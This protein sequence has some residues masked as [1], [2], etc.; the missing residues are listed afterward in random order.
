MID[1]MAVDELPVRISPC[2]SK[3]GYLLFKKMKIALAKILN[4]RIQKVVYKRRGVSPLGFDQTGLASEWSGG[5][6]AHTFN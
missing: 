4:S 3:Y 5:K 1:K 2:F 6:C